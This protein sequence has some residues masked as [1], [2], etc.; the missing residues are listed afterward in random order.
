MNSREQKQFRDQLLAES[1]N[2]HTTMVMNPG[3]AINSGSAS[4]S[5]PSS[6]QTLALSH[7]AGAKGSGYAAG[8]YFADQTH[9][10]HPQHQPHLQNQPQQPQM[11]HPQM[12]LY[13][14]TQPMPQGRQ[15]TNHDLVTPVLENNYAAASSRRGSMN[16]RLFRRKGADA[17]NFDEDTGADILDFAAALCSIND[18]THLRDPGRYNTMGSMSN[19][20]APIIPTLGALD[21]NLVK[22]MNNVQYRKFMNQQKKRNLAQSARAMSLAGGNPVAGGASSRSLSFLNGPY[23]RAMSLGGM[24]P[25]ASNRAM[26]LNSNA[27][28]NPALHQPQANAQF[29]QNPHYPQNQLPHQ[30]PQGNAMNAFNGNMPN[31]A[32]PGMRHGATSP[33]YQNAGPGSN[34]HT[35]SLRSN[36]GFQQRGPM[37]GPRA[38]SM[39]MRSN[40]MNG[41][42]PYGP[43]YL[44]P[45]NGPHPGMGHLNVPHLPNLPNH[46]NQQHTLNPGQFASQSGPMSQNPQMSQMSQNAQ[47][48]QMGQ[49]GQGGQ[50]GQNTR[51]KS[52]TDRPFPKNAPQS[53]SP[54]VNT[55]AGFSAQAAQTLNPNQ[56]S[57][58]FPG[59]LPQ[60]PGNALNIPVFAPNDRLAESLMNVL[61]EEEEPLTVKDSAKQRS[62]VTQVVYTD[63]VPSENTVAESSAAGSG[64]SW[65]QPEKSSLQLPPPSPIGDD[66]DHVFRFDDSQSPQVSRKNTIKK[67]NS[68]RVRKLDLFSSEPAKEAAA[69]TES[70]EKRTNVALNVPKSV[71]SPIRLKSLTAN[72]VFSNF[73]SML[74]LTVNDSTES[75][76]SKVDVEKVD[77]EVDNVKADEKVDEPK[78]DEPKLDESKVHE[79]KADE[80]KSVLVAADTQPSGPD[81]A[82]DSEAPLQ[83]EAEPDN[84]HLPSESMD[85]SVHEKEVAN[86]DG[87]SPTRAKIASRA[88]KGLSKDLPPRPVD[89]D[90]VANSDDEL[91]FKSE[92]KSQ[93]SVSTKDEEAKLANELSAN[94]SLR[95]RRQS[96]QKHV[97]LDHLAAQREEFKVDAKS[98]ATA[99]A[100]AEKPELNMVVPASPSAEIQRRA[101]ALSRSNSELKIQGLLPASSLLRGN[102]RVSSLSSFQDDD[103]RKEKRKSSVSARGLMKRLSMTSTKRSADE[104]DAKESVKEPFSFTKEELAIMTC[105]NDLQNEL[106]LVTSELAISIGR[107]LELESQLRVRSNKSSGAAEEHKPRGPSR[108]NMEASLAEKT[109]IIAELQ[110]K[111]NNERRLRF[112]SEEHAILAE[113]GQ[114]PS[115]LKLDY[116]K[117]EIYKQLLA[118]NDLVIQ[119]Q[120]KLDELS[121]TAAGRGID[122]DLHELFLHK[123]NDL[124]KENSELKARLREAEAHNYNAEDGATDDTSE[125]ESDAGALQNYEKE[126]ITSLRTQRDE[127]REMIVKLTVSQTTELK[128]ANDRIKTLEAKLEKLSAI[129]AKLRNRVPGFDNENGR[130]PDPFAPQGAR[131]Q[132]LSI[133]S[134]TNKLFD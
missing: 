106:Q 5:T 47:M 74:S 84:A 101:S 53:T 69:E 39:G 105:N 115:A 34:P 83:A 18:L 86:T 12:N 97:D 54:T 44:G 35:M 120:D 116:E 55:M 61:E 118:K 90:F 29:A 60:N 21:P 26:S 82:K 126:Q 20:S 50:N 80:S 7:D 52:F 15:L 62:V 4:T 49:M 43:S 110:E 66:G 108:S 59:T 9:P 133:V 117:N 129:N 42:G 79:P 56:M 130:N 98:D 77:V 30:L 114:L 57:P 92:S 121:P 2:G 103:E 40:P 58:R 23:E 70:P 28:L 81:V 123:Y 131:L 63:A 8:D 89:S 48:G 24:N 124:V 67:A 68:K 113:H 51:T 72:T 14:Q 107:E 93:K 95:N 11:Y 99:D 25:A 41:M 45:A 132:G 109:R 16:I 46:M 127:L 134:L 88:A 65:P 75:S 85:D 78:S 102:S 111:L 10:Q 71:R 37:P 36:S 22:G 96:S 119:L 38:N 125:D 31:G 122:G 91:D 128:V 33:Q 87:N 3:S 17:S 104:R 27:Y 6:S 13:N 73:R 1:S 76:E 64:E 94:S 32:R 112:I 19:D 100:T